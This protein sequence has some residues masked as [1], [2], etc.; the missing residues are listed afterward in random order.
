MISFIMIENILGMLIGVM[1]IENIL[2][3][4]ENILENIQAGLS[5]TD[6]QTT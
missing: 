1:L 3:M 2:G 6:A 4:L 5:T